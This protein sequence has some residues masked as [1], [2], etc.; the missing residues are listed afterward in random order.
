VNGPTEPTDQIPLPFGAYR[1]YE[2]ASYL[3]GGNADALAA[4]LQAAAGAGPGNIYLWGRPGTGKS[5]L[6][7]AACTAATG[8][9]RRAAYLPL[10]QA[11][12]LA[13]ELLT[14]LEQL[15]LVCVDDVDGIAGD[16]VWEQSLFHLFN[17]LR[18]NRGVM[19]LAAADSPRAVGIVLADLKS[20][21]AWDLCYHLQA[22]DEEGLSLALRQ[23]AHERGFD[24][25]EDVQQYI[26]RRVA[27][28]AHSLFD[29]LDRLDRVTL[30]AKRR[31]TVPLVRELLERESGRGSA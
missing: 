12:E 17:R 11:Q 13:P 19:V 27:R 14:G 7:Q 30:T 6:L 24:L 10:R 5:H 4:L 8:S 29:L 2:F 31:L 23:R 28:D 22:L 9:G 1:R 15:D 21:L 16:A 3:P 25:P 20:R 26:A 18:E